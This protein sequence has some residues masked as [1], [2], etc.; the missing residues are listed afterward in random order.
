MTFQILIADDYKMA[1]DKWVAYLA[2]LGDFTTTAVADVDEN[3][4]A[5]CW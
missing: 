3:E 1:R 5:A 4:V 2:A